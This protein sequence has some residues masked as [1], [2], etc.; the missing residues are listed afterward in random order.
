MSFGGV[1][2]VKGV[3]LDLYPGEV[4]A[5][6]GENGAGKSTMAK[7]IAGVHRPVAG[8]LEYL[9]APVSL[10]NPRH[11]IGL[12]IALIHQEPLTFPDLDVA[13]N[14]FV[15]HQ[16]V[17][18][19]TGVDWT[20]M[21]S[22][23]QELLDSLGVKF[24]PRARV[25]GLSVADQQMVE[26][27]CALS[28]DAKVLLMDETTAALT[29]KEVAELF[30]IVRRLKDQGRAIAFV[31]HHLEEV[32]EIADR[33]TVMRDGEKVGMLNPR[34]SSIDEVVRL[35]VGREVGSVVGEA[36]DLSDVKPILKVS[37]LTCP[38][39][40]SDIGFE[41]RP[42]E[43]VGLAGLV[44][45]G[46][47]DVCRS[48]FGI[49][50]LS[51]GTIEIDGKPVRIKSPRDAM[52]HGIALVPEDRQH[53]GLLMPMSLAEN[54]GLASLPKLSRLGWLLPKQERKL[55]EEYF[56]KLHTA[57]RS[58]TQPVRELSGGNQQ[59]IVLSKWMMTAP[60]ILILD[61]PTRGVDVGAKEEVHRLIRDLVRDGLAILVVS[62]DLP[63]L[64]DLSDRVLVMKE[65]RLT[66]SLTREQA[67][68]ESVMRAATGQEIHAA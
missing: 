40:F 52:S 57:F 26:L 50:R 28:H 9:G 36:R 23:A 34:E 21:R 55:A 7:I 33:I 54:A 38:G 3:D 58:V 20:S 29:P 17:R 1:E 60:R 22:R 37:G 66:A 6:V 68:P 32:F 43:I 61:E 62:S 44:G 39:R 45:A 8:S 18:G 59:K 64:L 11:A 30:T 24:S 4:H 49:Q 2:V 42:G 31:S 15:G 10:E 35:M 14:I 65:G 19:A 63:E 67:N 56:E 12:G 41:V 46:R 48:I 53:E 27:A 47:T 51:S 25:R 16:P 5:I 13:E